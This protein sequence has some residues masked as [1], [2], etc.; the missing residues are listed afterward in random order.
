M[1]VFFGTFFLLDIFLHSVFLEAE[2][3]VSC[4]SFHSSFSLLL[5]VR[6]VC[7]E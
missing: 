2:D 7:S 3:T 4:Y 1:V 5:G 6:R